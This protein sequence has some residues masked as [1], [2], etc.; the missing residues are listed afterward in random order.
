MSCHYLWHQW[1]TWMVCTYL[2]YSKMFSW[3]CLWVFDLNSFVWSLKGILSEQNNND[4]RECYQM[5]GSKNKMNTP[6]SLM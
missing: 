1:Q 3:S 6:V 5:V 4:Q 2:L